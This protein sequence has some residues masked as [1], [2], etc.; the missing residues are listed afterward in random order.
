MH[1]FT[2]HI[3]VSIHPAARPEL[4]VSQTGAAM[5]RARSA[6]RVKGP[7]SE[8][9]GARFRIRVCDATGQRDL[10]FST[11]NEAQAGIRQAERELCWSSHGRDLGSV[12][13]ERQSV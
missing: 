6:P 13:V 8:R 12:L 10:Y 1:L 9:G 5:P 4:R 7:Y 2:C 11:L 3:L